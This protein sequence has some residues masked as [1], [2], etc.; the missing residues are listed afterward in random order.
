MPAEASSSSST[1]A[2]AEEAAL[3]I[4]RVT[5]WSNAVDLNP[6]T[7]VSWESCLRLI[8]AES[9]ATRQSRQSQTDE[10]P[11]THITVFLQDGLFVNLRVD[12]RTTVADVERV[13]RMHVGVPRAELPSRLAL[14]SD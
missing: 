13:V 7:R 5:S 2:V 6:E 12:E 14:A 11:E 3:P 10:I 4:E 8:V 9:I 1:D